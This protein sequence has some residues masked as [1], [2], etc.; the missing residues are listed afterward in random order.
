MDPIADMFSQIKNA[1]GA[2]KESLVISFSK[3]KLA[4]LEILKT[5]RQVADFHTVEKKNLV[6]GE[7]AKERI[8]K[9]IEIKILPD[10]FTDIRRISRPGRRV[11]A[12]SFNIPRPKRPQAITIV[13]TSKG[14]LEGEDARRKGLGGEVI[15]EVK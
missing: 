14:V 4:I 9:T 3:I 13:S 11:Y 5:H 10:N 6:K 8:F 15:A 7:K 1:Q 2:R 12:S